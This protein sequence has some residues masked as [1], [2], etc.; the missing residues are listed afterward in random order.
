MWQNKLSKPDKNQKK[1]IVL[2]KI[3]WHNLWF[4]SITETV[5][6]TQWKVYIIALGE[7]LI[8]YEWQK[9]SHMQ[10]THANWSIRH[11]SKINSSK[12]YLKTKWLQQEWRQEFSKFYNSHSLGE[13]IMNEESAC[14]LGIKCC[15]I[16]A[17]KWN[18]RKQD[19]YFIR[20][21]FFSYVVGSVLSMI[22]ISE[23]LDCWMVSVIQNFLLKNGEQ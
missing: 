19:K 5:Q 18:I 4:F 17:M 23:R 21:D 9:T 22:R 15:I 1:K 20:P 13:K 6:Q 11:G 10:K 3:I 12:C 8:S 16:I 7:N 14:N 2:W